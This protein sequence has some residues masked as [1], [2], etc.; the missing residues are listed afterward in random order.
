MRGTQWLTITHNVR[1][2][3]SKQWSK[4]IV[5]SLNIAFEKFKGKLLSIHN[6]NELD[7]LMH[8]TLEPINIY[9]GLTGMKSVRS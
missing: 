4:E 3:K 8:V 7:R 1:Q 9:H 2:T 5:L 6:I